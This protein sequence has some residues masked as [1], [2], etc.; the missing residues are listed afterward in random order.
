MGFFF[1]FL[2]V[3]AEVEARLGDTNAARSLFRQA[4]ETESV[5]GTVWRAWAGMEAALGNAEVA[6]GLYANALRRA[7][8]DAV[9]LVTLAK[10]ERAGGDEAS[11]VRH[12][13]QALLVQP[14]VRS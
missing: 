12:F 10:L 9:T 8:G 4:T 7:P 3:W 6:R 11:A 2:Q 13:K 14:R 1:L 5:P